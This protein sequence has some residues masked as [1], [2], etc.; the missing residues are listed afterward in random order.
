MSELPHTSPARQPPSY[1]ASSSE[2]AS[3]LYRFPYPCSF[4]PIPYDTDT[5]LSHLLTHTIP[6]ARSTRSLSLALPAPTLHSSSLPP[7]PQT[8]NFTFS[9]PTP[10]ATPTF[11]SHLTPAPTLTEVHV[12]PDGLLLYVAQAAYEPGTSPLSNWVPIGSGNDDAAATTVLAEEMAWDGSDVGSRAGSVGVLAHEE[13]GRLAMFE[14][15]VILFCLLFHV[16]EL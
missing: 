7:F 4:V 6:A 3:N 8:T 12:R 10:S 16:N 9:L 2:E 15:F 11:G 13:E 5:T 1:G 14:R